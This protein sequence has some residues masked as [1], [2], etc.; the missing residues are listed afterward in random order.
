M[1]KS[2][3]PSWKEEDL[4]KLFCQS[5]DTR[6]TTSVEL[7]EE[8]STKENEVLRRSTEQCKFCRNTV[9]CTPK[10]MRNRHVNLAIHYESNGVS[11][12]TVLQISFQN[13]LCG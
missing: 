10:H 1:V 8:L 11:E 3:G 5:A 6:D 12:Y 2:L 7:S 13:G 9:L 4:E